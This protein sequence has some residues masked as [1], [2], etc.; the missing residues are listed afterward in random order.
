MLY[1][2]LNTLNEIREEV[3]RIRGRPAQNTWGGGGGGGEGVG[4]VHDQNWG[5]V[6]YN[7]ILDPVHVLSIRGRQGGGGGTMKTIDRMRGLF[8]KNIFFTSRN[9]SF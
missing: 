7:R 2:R 8:F 6:L 5:K 1:L 9:L 4:L 3:K